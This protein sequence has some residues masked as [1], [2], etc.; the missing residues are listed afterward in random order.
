MMKRVL[1][2]FASLLCFPVGLLAGEIT[3]YTH[4]HYEADDALFKAFTEET[5]IKVNVVK[6]GADQLMERLKQEGVVTIK[7][8]NEEIEAP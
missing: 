4:R 5:G 7:K 3:L 1:L 8:R 2:S 6:S